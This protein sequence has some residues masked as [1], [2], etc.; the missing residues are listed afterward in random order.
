MQVYAALLISF[1]A[2]IHWHIGLSQAGAPSYLLFVSNMFV[3]LAWVIIF[4]ADIS[5]SWLLLTILFVGL[6][7]L[8]R[9]LFR[10]GLLPEWFFHLRIRISMIV[11]AAST[12]MALMTNL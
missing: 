8:D 4:L 9:A 11:I 12:S 2:G 3:L 1:L 7:L 6:I 5:V 10:M